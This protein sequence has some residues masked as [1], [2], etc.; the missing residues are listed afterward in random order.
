MKS[1]H[2]FSQM[3]KS[4]EGIPA[5]DFDKIWGNI[6]KSKKKSKWNYKWLVPAAIMVLGLSFGSFANAG[7][8]MDFIQLKIGNEEV[9][10]ENQNPFQPD[11]DAP[12]SVTN[13]MVKFDNENAE[14]IMGFLPV[15]PAYLPEGYHYT[16]EEGISGIPNYDDKGKLLNINSSE[17]SYHIYYSKGEGLENHFQLNYYIREIKPNTRF[18]L[19][20]TNPESIEILGLQ[21]VTHDNG[22]LINKELSNNKELTIEIFTEG[23]ISKEELIKM[24]ESILKQL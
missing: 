10:V 15:Q 18:T 21:G 14:E 2:E 23:K 20:R 11:K 1:E 19:P 16:N 17:P 6:Q 4:S 24:M 22:V 8:L 12:E 9:V 13:H 3:M 7:K 5:P